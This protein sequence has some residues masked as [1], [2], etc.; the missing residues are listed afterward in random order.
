VDHQEALQ[1]LCKVDPT[2]VASSS[3]SSSSSPVHH[4][5]CPRAVSYQSSLLNK[6]QVVHR[7]PVAPMAESAKAPRTDTGNVVHIL[8][9]KWKQETVLKVETNKPLQDGTVT[10]SGYR[11]DVV[12]DLICYEHMW[13]IPETVWIKLQLDA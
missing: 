9:T 4:S 3:R 8:D 13:T 5:T 7:S 10:T 6:D 12:N 11:V 2:N 1:D